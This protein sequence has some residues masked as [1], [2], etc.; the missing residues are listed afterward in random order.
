[1]GD[2]LSAFPSGSVAG[3]HADHRFV[4]EVRAGALGRVTGAGQRGAQVLLDVDGQRPQRG[5]VDHAGPGLL[6]GRRRLGREPVDRPQERGQGLARAGGGEHQR[7]LAVGDRLPPLRLGRGGRVERRLEPVADGGG[8]GGEAHAPTLARNG[9][10]RRS[11]GGAPVGCGSCRAR[12]ESRVAAGVVVRRGTAG[13]RRRGAGADRRRRCRRPP[14]PARAPTSATPRI[15]WCCRAPSRCRGAVRRRGRG[16]PRT[17][18]GGG[19]GRRRRGR[20]RRSGL[21]RRTGERVG[22]GPERPDPSRG[23]GLGGRR[24][25]GLARPCGSRPARSWPATSAR[26][27][28]SRPAAP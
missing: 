28:P 8:E 24:R 6:V 27:W 20:A 10:T 4:R 26:T 22:G 9:D 14:R 21:R 11:A 13:P 15:R 17:R 2:E 23:H 18:V 3:A 12:S 19:R 1:M 25:A 16:L 7:V 5:D